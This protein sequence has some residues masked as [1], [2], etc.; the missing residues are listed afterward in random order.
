MQDLLFP[1]QTQFSRSLLA[2]REIGSSLTLTLFHRFFSS[3][4]VI[5]SDNDRAWGNTCY[6]PTSSCSRWPRL[7][8][9]ASFS[10]QRQS[11]SIRK[12]RGG[13]GLIDLF[14]R[15]NRSATVKLNHWSMTFMAEWH[16]LLFLFCVC[17]CVCFFFKGYDSA[18]VHV[19]HISE[20][21]AFLSSRLGRQIVFFCQISQ[22][23]K[24]SKKIYL[25]L[26]YFFL[27]LFPF[28]AVATNH[29]GAASH[30]SLFEVIFLYVWRIESACTKLGIKSIVK[31]ESFWYL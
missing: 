13:Q 28:S 10:D 9:I 25:K 15:Q 30:F 23:I 7:V 4:D 3:L 24:R 12:R 17:V 19:D 8:L 31:L 21:Y 16:A 29:T 5:D 26:D 22:T 1:S 6:L 14:W 20:F 18:R 27:L 2:W 11:S